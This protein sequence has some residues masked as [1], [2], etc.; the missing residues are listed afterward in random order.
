MPHGREDHC[1][2]MVDVTSKL[3]FSIY[4]DDHIST[5]VSVVQTEAHQVTVS[6]GSC[7]CYLVSR[8]TSLADNGSSHIVRMLLS[9]TMLLQLALRIYQ[10]LQPEAINSCVLASEGRQ[11]FSD[12]NDPRSVPRRIYMVRSALVTTRK[13]NPADLSAFGKQML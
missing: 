5:A 1:L 7:S 9:M 2:V 6:S 4:G 3:K 12:C 8:S 10:K 11:K 13:K